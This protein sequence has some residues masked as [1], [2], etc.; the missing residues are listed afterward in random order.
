MS[1]FSNEQIKNAVD[2]YFKYNSKIEKVRRELGYP[3]RHTLKK[4][5]EYYKTTGKYFKPKRK[6]T[7]PYTKSQKRIAVDFYIKNGKC[8]K[9][10]IKA[11]GYPRKI[12]TLHDWIKE[13]A[14]SE[15]R[16]V[17]VSENVLKYPKKQKEQAIIDLLTTNDSVTAVAKRN[18]VNRTSLYFWKEKLVHKDFDISEIQELSINELKAEASKLREEVKKLRLERD[19][20]EKAAE[21]IKKDQGIKISNLSNKEKM[22]VIDAL[23]AQY[24]LK[25]LLIALQISKSSYFYQESKKGYDKY[26]TIRPLIHKIFEINRCCYGYRRI[27]DSL[28]KYDITLSEKVVLHLMHEE[29]I[30]VIQPKIKKYSSYAG[31]ISPAVPN[32]LKRNFHASKPNQKWLTDI[33]EFIIPSGK[34]YLSPIID[35]FDGMVVSWTIGR[36]PSAELVNTML[37]IAIS[38][39]K[40]EERPIVHSDRGSH[41]RWPGWIKRMKNAKLKRSMSKKGYS[42]DNS[43]C[44]GFFGRLKNEMF[45]GHDWNHVS[46]DDFVYYLDDYIHWYNEDRIKHS[47]GGKS[48]LEFR[49]KLGLVA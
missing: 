38:K 3:D 9:D 26:K 37:D 41:Y 30:K 47:L 16:I 20:L 29:K 2:L 22:V 15:L 33:T 49:K 25:E 45:Y 28:K 36:S 6:E 46:I 40:P 24:P 19:I 10:T 11:L 23:R 17:K 32:L 43:A 7:S 42:P 35:C 48:P 27:Y 21:I 4:W 18:K 44:E 39:L 31:E 34:I 14:P 1:S 13:L 8:M 12:H 5:V